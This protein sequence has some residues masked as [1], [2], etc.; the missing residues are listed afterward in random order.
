MFPETLTV[1]H[2]EHFFTTRSTCS[3]TNDLTRLSL[4]R[5]SQDGS[6]K[7]QAF[8]PYNFAALGADPAA[9]RLHPLLKVRPFLNFFY[10]FYF[11]LS[12][13][14]SRGSLEAASVKLCQGCRAEWNDVF[15]W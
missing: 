15:S 5:F 4:S 6:W 7:T 1:F 14:E 12:T 11:F 2:H 3:K 13:T 9:G 10:F 8:K